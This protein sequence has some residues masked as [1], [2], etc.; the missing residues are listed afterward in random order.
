MARV[1]RAIRGSRAVSV[2][3]IFPGALRGASPE[4]VVDLARSRPNSHDSAI[5]QIAISASIPNMLPSTPVNPRARACPAKSPLGGV[6]PEPRSSASS[7]LLPHSMNK[8]PSHKRM[9][10]GPRSAVVPARRA[11]TS[12]TTRG[13]SHSKDHPNQSKTAICI[14][15]FN[16]K[17][18]SGNRKTCT[19]PLRGRQT[20]LDS[21]SASAAADGWQKVVGR[22]VMKVGD[23]NRKSGDRSRWNVLLPFLFASDECQVL[24]TR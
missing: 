11:L 7:A 17:S 15:K 23:I 21:C 12:R 22:L 1:T 13:I 10:P 5:V 9:D 18:T 3:S 24:C 4:R 14:L 20:P 16:E 6:D 19:G 8:V 2:V